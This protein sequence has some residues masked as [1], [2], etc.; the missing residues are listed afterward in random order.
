MPPPA[1][2]SFGRTKLPWRSIF[3]LD[4]GH[5]LMLN[6][7]HLCDLFAPLLRSL[8]LRCDLCTFVVIFESRCH[9]NL[10][11]CARVQKIASATVSIL[12]CGNNGDGRC[13]AGNSRRLA[14]CSTRL[15]GCRPRCSLKASWNSRRGLPSLLLCWQITLTSQI[16]DRSFN[17]PSLYGRY[18]VIS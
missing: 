6:L 7:S 12:N 8:H 4:R 10:N 14:Q 18:R 13:R 17:D 3:H 11:L 15:I 1:V 9:Q 5:T 16:G 2:L